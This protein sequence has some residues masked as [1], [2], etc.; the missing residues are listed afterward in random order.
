MV[1]IFN[2]LDRILCNVEILQAIR[3][4]S[5]RQI[6]VSLAPPFLAM[7]WNLPIPHIVQRLYAQAV[8]D[9]V[10]MYQLS[11]GCLHMLHGFRVVHA[12]SKK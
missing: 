11:K 12:A 8:L 7:N 5:I 1:L 4:D 9:I 3:W 10:K 2:C 6:D